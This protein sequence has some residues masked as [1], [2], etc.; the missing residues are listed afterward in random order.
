[1]TGEPVNV[2]GN[3]LDQIGHEVARARAKFPSPNLNMLAL[4]EEVGELAKALM[5]EPRANVR[6]EAVQ[7]AC[8]AIRVAL[9][10]DPSVDELRA[11]RGLDRGG[12]S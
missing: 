12:A 8:M 7:V 3:L 9:E 2:L 4:T 11:R 10:G 6:A 1:M 5:D